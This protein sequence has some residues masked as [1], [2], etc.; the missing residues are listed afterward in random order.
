MFPAAFLL[1]VRLVRT[2]Q[3]R[4]SKCSV[5]SPRALREKPRGSASYSF[6]YYI[7]LENLLWVSV[8]YGQSLHGLHNTKSLRTPALHYR[9]A[10]GKTRPRV[11]LS[12]YQH[13]SGRTYHWITGWLGIGILHA[14]Q[15][16]I[17]PVILDGRFQ[18]YSA[19]KTHSA[20]TTVREMKYISQHPCDK[21]TDG[22]MVLHR[23]CCFPNCAKSWWK[24]LLS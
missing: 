8:N 15:G 12:T 16:R 18:Q 11:K 21:I 24:K 22:K 4:F 7:F 13:R 23:E 20:F 2:L 3:H 6:T 5:R 14:D 1:A 9:F 17:Q 19:V 10:F